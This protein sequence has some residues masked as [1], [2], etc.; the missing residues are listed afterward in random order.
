MFFFKL[1]F[2]NIVYFDF[3]GCNFF[4]RNMYVKDKR[5]GMFKEGSGRVV[6]YKVIGIIYRYREIF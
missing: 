5:D 1:I 6:I 4:E 2:M 3:I